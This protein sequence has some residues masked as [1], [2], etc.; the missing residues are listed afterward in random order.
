LKIAD[1]RFHIVE[2]CNRMNSFPKG[3]HA[4]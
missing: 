4:D 2:L 1:N 3:P